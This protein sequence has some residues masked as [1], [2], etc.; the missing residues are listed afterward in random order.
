M[1]SRSV[2]SWTTL[3][4]GHARCGEC[5]MVFQL[6]EE[7][8]DDGV[9]PNDTTFLILLSVCSHVGL[10]DKGSMYF[11]EMEREY[12]IK[13]S[14]KHYNCMLDLL[15]RAGQLNEA[16]IMVENLPLS[17][18]LVTWKTILSACKKWGN[19]GIA[20]KTFE[21][22][23][24]MNE[25]HSSIFML[26]SNIYTDANMWEDLKKVKELQA[27]L[28]L[29]E[30]IEKSWIEEGNLVHRFVEGDLMYNRDDKIWLK[31][32]QLPY[33]VKQRQPLN[34][35][36]LPMDSLN[37]EDTHLSHCEEIAITFGLHNFS[38]K[39]P[40]RVV[41]NLWLH[42]K[43]HAFMARTSEV[44]HRTIICRDSFKF[45]VFRDGKCSCG[46]Q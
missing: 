37:N 1:P 33:N 35:E 46:A 39:M 17:P 38:D 3:I 34:T 8:V 28:G 32:N 4:A 43:C 42:E 5:E 23:L 12:G 41:K 2:I 11:N 16:M 22:A 20:K 24:K 27:H 13:P 7:M 14:L 10:V 19:V 15:S 30:N 25:K 9:R 21:W 29:G 18:N 26:M 31:V 40:L 36:S 45:H 6:F 44:E